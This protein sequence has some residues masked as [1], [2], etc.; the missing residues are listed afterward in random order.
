MYSSGL[1]G[2]TLGNNQSERVALTPRRL[3]VQEASLKHICQYPGGDDSVCPVLQ[4]LHVG[5]VDPQPNVFWQL[6]ESLAE[7]MD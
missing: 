3:R 5:L 4:L 7:Q 2:G 1:A 6:T